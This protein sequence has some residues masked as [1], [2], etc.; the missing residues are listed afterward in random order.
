MAETPIRPEVDVNDLIIEEAANVQ[1][2]E[3]GTGVQ[4]DVE[5]MEDGSAI[6]NPEEMTVAQGDFG[7][8]LAE[9]VEETELNK[10]ADD[11]FGLYDEDKSS[12]GD[13]EKAYVDG[14]DLLG[15]KYT[16]RTQPFTGAS[17]VTHPLLAETVTQFQAQAYKELLPADGPV[18]TQIVGAIDPQVQ[19]QANRVKD[20]MNYQIMDVMEEYDPDMD[21]LLFFL[22]LAGSAF[23][24]I[25][26]SDLKQRAVAEFIPAEDI[27]LPYLTTDIQSCERVC[28]VVTMMDNELRKKQASGFFRDIDIK[29]SLPDDSD[30]QNKYNDLDGTN[31]ETSMDVYNLLEFHVDLDL[32]GFEDPS[33]VKVPY[34]VTIDKGSNK[35]LSIYR[36]WNP[37]DPLKK[38]IQYFVHYKFL[39]G[40]GFYG[41][42]L[43]HMLGGL[44]RTATA[45][46]RQLIDA[47]TLSNLPAGFKARGLRIRD[48]DNP[49][50]PG[51]F[52]DV[53]AP[54]GNLREGLVPLP[55]KGPDGVLF[56]L[57]GFVVE[58]GTRFAAIADQKIGEGSQANPVGT[59][60]ALIERGTKVMNA[61]HKRLHY[62]QKKEFK[63]LARVIQLY[64]P[65]EYPY[66]VKGG[67]QMIK[68]SDFDDRVDII[69]VSDPNIFSMAQ[70][71]TLAQTQMQMAQAAPELHNMYEA[72]RRMYM[73]LG[74]RDIE[75]ILPQPTQP[76]PIDP[77]REN[78]NALA[79]QKLNA[80]PGQDHQAHINAHRG[81]MSSFLIRQNPQVMSLLQA[82]ISEHI[83][84][85]ATEEIEQLMAKELQEVQMAVQ[86][87]Q[88]DPARM[89]QAQQLAQ[90]AELA[91]AKQIATRVAEITDK[92]LEEEEEMLEARSQDPLVDLKQQEIDLREKDIQRKAME[93]QQKLDF[94]DKKLG[95]N[96]NMQQEKIQSQEDIAQ[97]RANVNLE[98]MDKDMRNKNIDLKETKIREKDK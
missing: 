28:H 97:L 44:S 61:I 57:L 85:L 2:Q 38:K 69:P 14:L 71:V 63:L 35:V 18:R 91:K 92:M 47:G 7:L 80:F 64:L 30:I 33:G 68:Q 76:A 98:K 54:S 8:N 13:W 46:L 39:P 73:A 5:I 34:I 86:Q 95:Q 88:Q 32:V 66:M 55:Y 52:R 1:I 94:Q 15:F 72:Y 10:L 74:V 48:D 4:E 29:P 26:Y 93:E 56:Q 84:L 19:E 78:A 27:V 83:S 42:G 51:E 59:T 58:A 70:R 31:E 40:L 82:H 87:A 21:Q 6:V 65:P 62:S 49:L 77:A 20:F 60:M 11:L 96:T 53:D 89:Q 81:F 37:N 50:Q 45:A 23:K 9:V 12:R 43:I 22:P 16:D 67:N 41:F 36:N 3:P 90:Q 75:V 17:S 79:A 25:Y 24:K